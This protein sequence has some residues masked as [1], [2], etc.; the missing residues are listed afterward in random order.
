[1]QRP[2]TADGVKTVK[3]EREREIHEIPAVYHSAWQSPSGQFGLIC[4]NWTTD[5]QEF[6]LKHEQLGTRVTESISSKE[7]KSRDREVTG[8]AIRVTLPP[9]SC[10]LIGS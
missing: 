10:G 7:L 6:E 9:L 1:M 8:N 4:A 3:W 2:A 5:S